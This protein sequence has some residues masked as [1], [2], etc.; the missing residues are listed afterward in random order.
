MKESDIM[1]SDCF[2]CEGCGEILDKSQITPY[3]DGFCHTIAYQVGEYD[4]EPQPCG[5][6]K[7]CTSVKS[8]A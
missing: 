2:R 8:G 6:V 3:D 7:P 5:P 1:K 4:W